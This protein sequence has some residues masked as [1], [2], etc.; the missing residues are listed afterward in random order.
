MRVRDKAAFERVL[1]LVLAIAIVT[2]GS[3]VQTFITR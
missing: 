2:I 1:F 3:Y